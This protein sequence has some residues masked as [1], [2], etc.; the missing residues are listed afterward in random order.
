MTLNVSER[1]A[2]IGGALATAIP[3]VANQARLDRMLVDLADDVFEGDRSRA[4]LVA[5]GLFGAAG[6]A[7]IAFTLRGGISGNQGAVFMSLGFGFLG[8]AV[9]SYLSGVA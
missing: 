7:M 6:L 2:A 3:V 9:E 5:A 1:H 8:L 4:R